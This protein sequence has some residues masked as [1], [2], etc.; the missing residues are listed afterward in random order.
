MT[1]PSPRLSLRGVTVAYDGH[2]ALSD[3][4]V[5]VG[6]G[7]FLALVG[8]SGS[9]KTTLLKTVNRL[10]ECDAGAVFIDG[11]PVQDRSAADLRRSIGYVFQDIGL[12]PHMTVAQ[13]IWLVPAL[14][15]AERAGRDARVAQLLDMVALPRELAGRMATQLSGGQ[16]QRVGF[17]RALAAEP[18]TVLMDEPFGALDPVT[19]GDLGRA[20]RALHDTMGLTTVMVTHDMGEAMLL[21]DRIAVMRGGRIAACGTPAELLSMRDDET[22][23]GL[24]AEPLRQAERLLAMRGEG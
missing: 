14:T 24:L 12:F 7:E 6:R 18:Q 19:R 16:A 3:V 17:A 1:E 22:V 4:D 5:S 13:N 23:G 8:P 9:G 20:Y 11:A 10:V 2:R 21:S 15:G